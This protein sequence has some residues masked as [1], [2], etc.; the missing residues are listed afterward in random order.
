MFTEEDYYKLAHARGQAM[1]APD[2]PDFDA[3][4]MLA[5]MGK[6]ENL[7]RSEIWEI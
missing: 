1:A 5:V 4:S 6:V 3:G 7:I 2:D